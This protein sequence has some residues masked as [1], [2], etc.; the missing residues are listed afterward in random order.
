MFN[1]DLVALRAPLDP[2][3]I[4]LGYGYPDPNL[5]PVEALKRASAAALQR[6]GSDMLSYGANAGP[7]PLLEWLRARLGACDGRAPELNEIMTTSGNSGALDQL[8]TLFTQPGDVVL[9]ESPTYYLAIR[10]LRDHP[11]DL[12]PVPTDEEGL[13]LDALTEALGQLRR[14]GKCARALYLVPTFG[15]PTG[16]SLS[17]ERRKA[18]IDMAAREG[19]M[20]VEDDVYRELAYDTPAPPSLWSMDAADA[21]HGVVF[22]LGSFSKTLGPGLRLGWLTASREVIQRIVDCGLLDSGGGNNHFT[23]C[24]VTALCEDGE[25]EAQVNKLRTAYRARRDALLAALARHMP[26]GCEWHTPGGGFFVW[27]KMPDGVRSSQLRE[28]AEAHGMS[29]V[30][31]TR[32]YLD[33]NGEDHVRLSFTLYPPGALDEATRRL[34]DVLA[35]YV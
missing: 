22:R 5:L 23:A 11:L 18:L 8:L 24:V 4:D 21:R 29:L 14:E 34:G 30:P 26:D 35:T 33:G 10:I 25:Y 32:F 28:R 6:Y 31:G 17:D 1:P 9:V 12:I 13:R 2:N 19:L 15:N 27:V 7:V 16:V 20:I 3:L